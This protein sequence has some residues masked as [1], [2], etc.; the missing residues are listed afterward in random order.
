VT[1][2]W[3]VDAR[4]APAAAPTRP[5]QHPNRQEAITLNG[6]HAGGDRYTSVVQPLTRDEHHQPVWQEI[7]LAEYNQPVTPG[8]HPVGVLDELFCA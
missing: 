3:F 4:T 2:S 6:R 1:E 5:S 8:N 7:L